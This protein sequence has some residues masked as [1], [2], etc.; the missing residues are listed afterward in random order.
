MT[1][2]LSIVVPCYNE[3]EA[4]PATVAALGK[5]LSDVSA[6]GLAADASEIVFVDDG[7]RDLTWEAI[8]AAAASDPRIVGIKLSRN[9]GHQNAVLAGMQSAQ[10]DVVITIDA[11]LQDDTQAIWEMLKAAQAGADI[12]YGV[13]KSRA[14]DTFFKRFT[15]E[16]YYRILSLL[17]VEIVFNHADF[18]LL[19][20]R[21]LNAL[22]QFSEVNVF[23]RGIV[24]QLG[25]N[26]SVVYYDRFERVSG[27][28]KYPLRK[29][30]SLAWQGITS[31][32]TVP[33][34]AITVLGLV[35]SLLSIVVSLWAVL[36]GLFTER[37]V[38]GWTS[39]IV[40][41]LLLGGIQL[42]CLGV[43]GEYMGKIYL[44]VK[45]RPRYFIAESTRPSAEKLAAGTPAHE[46]VG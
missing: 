15:A 26:T 4:F 27:E 14:S 35:V 36:I 1:I 23:L 11:D 20:R 33:L 44:E 17:G 25:F 22:F 43:I 45:G 18:R 29:M 7:S 24:P 32:S 28:S 6:A 40:P 38:P 3:E 41:I 42:L 46:K 37:T 16:G 30:L 8:T 5:L 31:F 34:K 19:S 10:G 2:K 13:R 9:R 21:A 12:V 39:T